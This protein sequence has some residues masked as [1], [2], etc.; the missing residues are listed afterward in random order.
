MP[1]SQ[2][3]E[4]QDG[5]VEDRRLC[6]L[7]R[8]LGQNAEAEAL[9][10]AATRVDPT[11]AEAWHNLGDL[12][13]EQ[14]RSNAAIECLRTALRIAPD[15]ADAKSANLI[16]SRGRKINWGPFMSSLISRGTFAKFLTDRRFSVRVWERLPA[17][18]STP[19]RSIARDSGCT[20]ED[21]PIKT[22]PRRVCRALVSVWGYILGSAPSY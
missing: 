4:R 10:R 20:A 11:F 13:D 9:L 5:P 15:Y 18:K 12:L 3:V 6:I 1:R 8:V 21:E 7:L 22:G 14:G 2:L 19:P 17:P 16:W